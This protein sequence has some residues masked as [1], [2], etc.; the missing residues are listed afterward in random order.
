M[1]RH[2]AFA[3]GPRPWPMRTSVTAYSR[4]G[5][6]CST[7]ESLAKNQKH[8]RDAKAVCSVKC[9]SIKNAGFT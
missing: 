5:R 7:E 4:G 9:S 6:T 2:K 1:S 3:R 8:Q